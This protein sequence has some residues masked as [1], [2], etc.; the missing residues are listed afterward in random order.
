MTG[1][2]GGRGGQP[3]EHV[4]SGAPTRSEP[5]S[6][7]IL[8]VG[9]AETGFEDAG[10]GAGAQDLQGNDDEKGE[11]VVRPVEKE[12]ESEQ[13]QSAENVN[14]IANAGIEAMRDELARLRREGE[15]FAELD[16]SDGQERQA[17]D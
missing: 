5:G 1:A 16:T 14:G 17:E 8:A 6:G 10:F 9:V 2:S 3:V 7:A 12:D 15:R 4:M 11:Q 13:N